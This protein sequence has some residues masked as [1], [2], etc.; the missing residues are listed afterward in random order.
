MFNIRRIFSS[1]SAA[2]FSFFFVLFYEGL[3]KRSQ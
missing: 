1:S 3:T 2:V